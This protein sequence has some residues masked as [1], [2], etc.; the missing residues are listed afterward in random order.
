[1]KQK[2]IM[3]HNVNVQ[4]Q[5][6]F[7][8]CQESC[9]HSRSCA[10]HQTANEFRGAQGATPDLRQVVEG[11][12]RCHKHPKEAL[13]GAVMLDGRFFGDM[14]NGPGWFDGLSGPAGPPRF[15]NWDDEGE[16]DED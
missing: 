15:I 1:M 16:E 10:N 2:K 13:K 6:I 7:P 11:S 9:S 5:N 8:V 3:L 14:V 4:L 12:W